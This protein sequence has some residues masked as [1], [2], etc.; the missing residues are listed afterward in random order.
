M[1][2]LT[3]EFA[4]HVLFIPGGEDRGGNHDYLHC[5]I[6][7]LYQQSPFQI[8]YCKPLI[9][10]VNCHINLVQVMIRNA[11]ALESSMTPHSARE[12]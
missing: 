8:T 3:N 2:C 9:Q 11:V 4:I 1:L 5:Y 7:P 6:C 10:H 12:L